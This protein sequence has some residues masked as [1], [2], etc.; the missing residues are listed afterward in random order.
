[1]TVQVRGADG[2][3][4]DRVKRTLYSTEYGPIVTE[5]SGIPLPWAQGK[6]FAMGDANAQNFRYLNHFFE[7]NMAQSVR[8]YDGVLRRNQGIPWV[9]SIAADSNGEAYY[10]DISVVPHVTDEHASALQHGARHA[11]RSRRCGCRCSTG[12]AATCAWG[13]DPSAVQPGILGPA[14]HLPSMFRTDYTMNANDSYWLSNLKQKLE[15]FPRIVGDERTA[16]SLRTRI[17]LLMIDGKKMSL[18]DLQDTVFNNRQYAGE[19]WRDEAVA[20]CD[21]DARHGRGVRGAAGVEPARRPRLARARCCGGASRSGCSSAARRRRR[22]RS[23]CRSTP[24]T[25]RTRRAGCAR[26]TRAWRRRCATRW[27]SCAA[28]RSRSTRRSA[29]C[30]PRSRGGERLPIHGGPGTAGVFNAINVAAADLKPKTGYETIPHGSSFVQAVQFVDGAVPGRRRGRS[31]PTRSRPTPTSAWHSDQTRMFGR[32]EWN[33]PPFCEDDVVREALSTTVAAR[34][35]ARGRHRRLPAR[36]RTS[37][38]R[39]AR[40]RGRRDRGVRARPARSA[41]VVRGAPAGRRPCAGPAR[42]LVSGG[43]RRRLPRPASAPGASCAATAFV[44]AAAASA[45]L[46]AFERREP[47]G[48]IRGASLASPTVGRTLVAERRADRARRRCRS[49]SCGAGASS[50][51]SAAR[52]RGTRYRVR[53]PGRSCAAAARTA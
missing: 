38:A 26:R 51:G 3:L 37:A 27:P 17:G 5:L 43:A 15:G 18:R 49:T 7:T 10:A 8:E 29:R 50:R 12:R 31:S 40:V 13:R 23:R 47:C 41:E 2:K 30:R 48:L 53:I 45:T 1:M 52:G 9:N 42:R 33:A 32:K 20:A 35:L 21:R 39:R 4:A 25:R 44:G 22:R 11:R 6:A 46:P 36:R 28:S 34:A 24:T 14:E 19:L 16:R